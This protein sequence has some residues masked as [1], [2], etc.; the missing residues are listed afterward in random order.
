MQN[1]DRILNKIGTLPALSPIV[2]KLLVLLEDENS[3]LEEIARLISVDQ[4]FAVKVL[5]FAN[6]A[7]FGFAREISSIQQA[8]VILGTRSIK[9]IALGISVFHLDKDIAPDLQNDILR[10]EKQSVKCAVYAQAIARH[11]RLPHLD[12]IF[13]SG[14]LH[15]VGRL[16]IIRC[17]QEEYRQICKLR[18]TGYMS[19]IDAEL[20]VLEVT[21][22]DVG[23]YMLNQWNF[24]ENIVAVIQY[25]H[26]PHCIPTTLADNPSIGYHIKIIALTQLLCYE[27]ELSAS[28]KGIVDVL[29]NELKLSLPDLESVFENAQIELDLLSSAFDV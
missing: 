2:N 17:L 20:K 12:D 28:D 23:A 29:L 18:E 15:D 13:V 10:L 24:P 6:S 1:L 26:M 9:N 11:L 3:S 19:L 22:M 7:Y 21:H 14:L 8:I 25:H 16:V 27:N 4:A 5:R